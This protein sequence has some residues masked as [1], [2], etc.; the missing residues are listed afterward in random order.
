MPS[1]ACTQVAESR[2]WMR[3]MRI[4]K[5]ATAAYSTRHC[6]VGAV[7]PTAQLCATRE[8]SQSHLGATPPRTPAHLLVKAQAPTWAQ[9]TDR[10]RLSRMC[11]LLVARGAGDLAEPTAHDRCAWLGRL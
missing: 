4:S 8:Q 11:R 7:E 5:D 6:G 1:P 2:R 9:G 10:R 3:A